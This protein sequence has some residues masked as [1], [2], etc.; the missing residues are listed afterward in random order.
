[1][2]EAARG[3]SIVKAVEGAFGNDQFF[4][5]GGA[6]QIQ[7]GIGVSTFFLVVDHG[8]VIAHI[9]ATAIAVNL[10]IDVGQIVDAYFLDIQQLPRL[11][12][13]AFG[14]H[15]QDVVTLASIDVSTVEQLKTTGDD[16]VIAI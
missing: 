1:N 5:G 14:I 13:H 6:G 4:N 16:G 2:G 7:D 10:S 11:G 3:V 12:K 8:V 9:V 15:F